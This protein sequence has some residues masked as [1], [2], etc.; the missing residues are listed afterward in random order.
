[1]TDPKMTDRPSEVLRNEHQVILRVLRVLEHLV[2]TSKSG[3]SFEKESL[4]ECVAFFRLFADACHH[5]KEEDLLFPEL[6][7][8][9]IPRDGGPIGCMLEEHR[10]ARAYTKAMGEALEAVDRGEEGAEKEF[11]EA[12]G[13]YFELLSNHIFKEDNVLFTMGDRVLTDEDQTSLCSKFCEVGCKSFGGKTREQLE[14]M[15]DALESRW[16]GGK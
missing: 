16:I 8:R 6:E 14:Q 1:M 4:G 5:A 10:M 12:A 15:A 9:G 13:Q 2:A 11:H 3:G 7:K